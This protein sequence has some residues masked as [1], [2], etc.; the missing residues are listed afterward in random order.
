MS[1]T[2]HIEFLQG[3]LVSARQRC[4]S[5]CYHKMIMAGLISLSTEN[6]PAFW[7]SHFHSVT[8]LCVVPYSDVLRKKDTVVD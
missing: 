3:M 2:D 4:K 6:Q 7:V 1:L 5:S 8:I